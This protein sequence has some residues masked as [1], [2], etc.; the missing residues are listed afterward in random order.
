MEYLGQLRVARWILQALWI[1][2]YRQREQSHENAQRVVEM[3]FQLS[4]WAINAR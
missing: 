3:V 1:D 4:G 2:L